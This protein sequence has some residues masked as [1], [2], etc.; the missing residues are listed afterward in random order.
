M[1]ASILIMTVS[2][3]LFLYW[4]RYTCRLILSTRTTKDY[5]AEVVAANRLSYVGFE[6]KLEELASADL[7]AVQRSLER[8][9]QLVSSLLQQAGELKMGRDSL[10]NL[11]L[12]FDYRLMKVLYGVSRKLS[13]AQSRSAVDEMVQIVAHMANA[14]GEQA[15]SSARA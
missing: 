3:G 5:S 7:D 15:S 1:V 9:Y 11:M 8:D 2:V 13:E 12:R 14:F 6:G 10:E 4:F